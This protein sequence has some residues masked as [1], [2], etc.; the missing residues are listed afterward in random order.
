MGNGATMGVNY[1]Q[2]LDNMGGVAPM[3][4]CGAGSAGMKKKVYEF[5]KPA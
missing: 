2:R 3:D 5:Y 4:G 1:I